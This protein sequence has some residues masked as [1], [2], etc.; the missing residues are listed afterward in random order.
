MIVRRKEPTALG[1]ALGP[2][3]LQNWHK[4]RLA[5]RCSPCITKIYPEVRL[6]EFLHLFGFEITT[7]YAWN[8][9]PAGFLIAS[10]ISRRAI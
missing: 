10:N 4:E 1:L 5:V 2:G 3:H 7:A 6:L 9:E 8:I